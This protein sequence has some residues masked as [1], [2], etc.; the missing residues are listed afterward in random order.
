MGGQVGGR[1]HQLLGRKVRI[2]LQLQAM[3]LRLVHGAHAQ[4]AVYEKPQPPI[5][6]DL[7]S[8]GMWRAHQTL[9]LKIRHDVTH[10]GR[11]DFDAW[12]GGQQLGSHRRTFFNIMFNEQLQKQLSAF[13][14]VVFR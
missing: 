4:Q 14:E 3:H 2:E 5:R 12:L 6:G 9:G 1:L 13:I 11:T 7:A 10:G 8:R